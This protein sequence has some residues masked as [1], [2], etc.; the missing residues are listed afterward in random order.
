MKETKPERIKTTNQLWQKT[1]V[2]AYKSSQKYQVPYRYW[3]EFKGK[4]K[5]GTQLVDD[6]SMMYARDL[7]VNAE[8]DISRLIGPFDRSQKVKIAKLGLG[9]LRSF[10]T[11][12]YVA[13]LEPYL[14]KDPLVLLTPTSRER[15]LSKY[16]Q[17]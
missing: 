9:E 10:Y 15:Y 14:N 13:Y 8:I 1:W 5:I 3:K 12:D 7:E 6:V 4:V 17:E 16:N 11:E 2:D